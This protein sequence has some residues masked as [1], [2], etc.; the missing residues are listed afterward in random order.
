MC[1]ASGSELHADLPAHETNEVELSAA[2]ERRPRKHDRVTAS[3]CRGWLVDT[4]CSMDS[5]IN[6][7]ACGRRF[8]IFAWRV[9]SRSRGLF[10]KATRGEYAVAIFCT[11]LAEDIKGL[12]KQFAGHL[13]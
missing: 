12:W 9:G 8:R 3:A 2:F 13:V 5:M 7:L 1:R 10:R 6:A 11:L 4:D